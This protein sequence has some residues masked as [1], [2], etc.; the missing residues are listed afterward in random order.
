M[1]HRVSKR[2]WESHSLFTW[3]ENRV[4][5][6][7]CSLLLPRSRMRIIRF[8]VL[9]ST[10]IFKYFEKH[11]KQHVNLCYLPFN[12]LDNISK[13]FVDD[14]FCMTPLEL[15]SIIESFNFSTS[16]IY[17]FTFV[18]VFYVHIAFLLGYK[19]RSLMILSQFITQYWIL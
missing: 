16:V 2:R 6:Q 10:F 11:L 12:R 4:V 7:C 15:E 3:T 9:M 19:A 8:L 13:Q 5:N 17:T 1:L 18:R 14:S